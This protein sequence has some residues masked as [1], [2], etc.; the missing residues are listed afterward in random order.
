MPRLKTKDESAPRGFS[1]SGTR[2]YLSTTKPS[3]T[4]GAIMPPR[5]KTVSSRHCVRL[6][7]GERPEGRYPNHPA[8]LPVCPTTVMVWPAA[9]VNT[10]LPFT[11]V[12]DFMT[13]A[14]STL[15]S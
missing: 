8:T 1:D 12:A 7:Q 13:A 11:T 14:K 5:F 2:T 10:V 3:Q 4:W 6:R 9:R 15:A